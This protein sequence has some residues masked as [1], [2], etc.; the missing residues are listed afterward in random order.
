MAESKDVVVVRANAEGKPWP[1]STVT[2]K[3]SVDGEDK[4]STYTEYELSDAG[5]DMA[6][7]EEET[8]YLVLHYRNQQARTAARNLTA[9]RMRV[10]GESKDYAAE[11]VWAAKEQPDEL[12]A[13]MAGGAETVGN[14]LR[15]TRKV[16]KRIAE[17][18]KDEI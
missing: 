16:I 11:L 9:S 15:Q 10:K 6:K 7:A 14:Y 4:E 18:E 8:P 3:H 5:E 2:F 17:N 12:A 1:A 13:A